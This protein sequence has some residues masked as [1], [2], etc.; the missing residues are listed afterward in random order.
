MLT[1]RA[2]PGSR[3]PTLRSV[4]AEYLH[5]AI[6]ANPRI[7]NLDGIATERLL[8]FR[9]SHRHQL[10]AFC[11]HLASLEGK[12]RKIAAVEDAAALRMHLEDLYSQSNA[13][14]AGRSPGQ[15]AAVQHQERSRSSRAEAGR[16]QRAADLARRSFGNGIHWSGGCACSVGY[17]PD[18][19]RSGSHAIRHV[20]PADSTATRRIARVVHAGG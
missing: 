7:V 14:V 19:H 6:A 5:V 13:A 11:A 15:H 8:D 16:E 1:G 20:T 4:E 3:T 18:C 12:L 17:G 9:A 10:Q 2:R